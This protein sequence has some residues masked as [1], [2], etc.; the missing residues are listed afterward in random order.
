MPSILFLID[1]EN[2]VLVDKVFT[3]ISFGIKYLLKDIK[4]DLQRFYFVYFEILNNKN[5]NVRRFAA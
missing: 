2:V 4:S 5:K 3:L 1:I